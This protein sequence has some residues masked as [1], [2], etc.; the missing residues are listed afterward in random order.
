MRRHVAT[1][2]SRR[3]LF[4]TRPRAWGSEWTQRIQPPP[5]FLHRSRSVAEAIDECSSADA[6]SSS[7]A[8]AASSSDAAAA[9]SSDAAAASSSSPP[10]PPA[11]LLTFADVQHDAAERGME[12]KLRTI[13][14]WWEVTLEDRGGAAGGEPSPPISSPPA[15]ASSGDPPLL[16]ARAVGVTA[17]GIC[18]LDSL[19]VNTRR[20]RGS[21]GARTR[22]GLA[23]TG[24]LMARAVFAAAF[25]RAGARK[26]EVL[27]VDDGAPG[28]HDRLVRAYGR[29]AGFEVVR[30]VEGGRV[31][32]LPHQLVWGAVGSRMDAGVEEQLRKWGAARARRRAEEGPREGRE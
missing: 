25:E 11:P 15:S 20:A 1:P 23:G 14:P 13:G 29:V 26:V 27:A 10:P 6:A 8:A 22:P 19:V 30:R 16:L 18:H 31:G 12:L 7:N 4:T 32:D 9:S 21:A 24:G 17:L 5:V 28:E 2:P 3:A